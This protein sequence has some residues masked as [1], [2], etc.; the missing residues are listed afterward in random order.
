MT[1][2][3]LRAHFAPFGIPVSSSS[4]CFSLFF[5]LRKLQLDHDTNRSIVK[6]MNLTAIIMSSI[7]FNIPRQ[8]FIDKITSHAIPPW[9]WL[10]DTDDMWAMEFFFS[11]FIVIFDIIIYHNLSILL[12]CLI[13]L[14]IY[15]ILGI[16]LTQVYTVYAIP[17]HL[18]FSK[19]RI[20]HV[21]STSCITQVIPL[22]KV[23]SFAEYHNPSQ[24]S[25][26]FFSLINLF[27]LSM[28]Y[29]PSHISNKN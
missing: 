6:V 5:C 12:W 16:F 18:Y 7:N 21:L 19:I 13:P 23:E 20:R 28:A 8:P 22:S 14:S 15:W 9:H 11:H 2:L 3:V 26:T 4:V 10:V 24:L 17:S 25:T 27:M 1:V 29:I